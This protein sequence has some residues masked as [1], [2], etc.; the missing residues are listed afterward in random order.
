MFLNLT[1]ADLAAAISDQRRL[2]R[3]SVATPLEAAVRRDS[4][5]V[6]ANQD[7]CDAPAETNAARAARETDRGYRPDAPE[8]PEL[9]RAAEPLSLISPDVFTLAVKCERRRRAANA[10]MPE[11][12]APAREAAYNHSGNLRLS[13]STQYTPT[14]TFSVRS[15]TNVHY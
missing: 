13:V 10:R 9:R 7:K 8:L 3:A 1:S 11:K 4:A 14:V 12:I 15:V 2:G 6:P 5:P